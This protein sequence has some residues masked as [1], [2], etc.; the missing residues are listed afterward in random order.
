MSGISGVEW[1]AVELPSQ[2][3]ENFCWEWE[4][5]QRLTAHVDSGEPLP[6]H[7]FDR[8]L[9]A[10]NF[11]SGLQM[12]RQVEFS[13]I[14]MRLHAEPGNESRIDALAAEVRAE[15]SLVPTPAFNRF[16]NSFSHI[17]AGGYAAGYYS[18]KWA[19]VLSADAWSAFEEAATTGSVLDPATGRRYRRA[20]LEA[21]AAA[22]P[23]TAS[24]PFAAASR[25]S[26]RCCG[27][28]GSTT[29]TRPR[30]EQLPT[31]AL[32]HGLRMGTIADARPFAVPEFAMTTTM[33]PLSRLPGLSLRAAVCAAACLAAGPSLALYKVV[34]PDGKVTYTDRAPTSSEGRVSPLNSRAVAVEAEPA[35]P[36]ELRQALSRYPV[37]LYTIAG[38]C[39]PC[40]AARALLRTRGVP[41]A[42]RQVVS[43]EDGDA[44]QKLTGGRDAPVLAIG[45]QQ[46]RGLSPDTWNSYLDSAGYPRESKLPPGYAF[47]SPSP[48]TERREAPARQAPTAAAPAEPAP[49]AEGKFRF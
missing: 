45:T 25:A 13:L 6:R 11:H 43:A 1:D 19:E 39:E 15:V 31:T 34:G 29:V 17:F 23:W 18:Y 9:A 32:V 33:R 36:A 7:L 49:P 41:Y 30:R 28:R 42:E 3:M 46:L 8:M 35:M 26:T 5:L 22:A 40:D 16:L 10:K 21:A 48:L 24:R 38:S 2:F 47:A 14:D 27:T 44:F 37:T 4:V 20:I 12:L